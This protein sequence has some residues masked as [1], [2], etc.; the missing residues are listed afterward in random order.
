MKAQ[1]PQIKP[2]I[3]KDYQRWDF[4]FN[5]PAIRTKEQ[6]IELIKLELLEEWECGL[7]AKEYYDPPSEEEKDLLWEQFCSVNY[8][9]CTEETISLLY[10]DSNLKEYAIVYL[11]PKLTA[12][13]IQ[14]TFKL[15][16]YSDDVTPYLIEAATFY[17][18][19]R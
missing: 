12:E 3:K 2:T 1:K 7:A 10:E 17:A 9:L 14:G 5:Q 18:T 8:A 13:I 16:Q 6:L 4:K 19:T 11:A 15:D